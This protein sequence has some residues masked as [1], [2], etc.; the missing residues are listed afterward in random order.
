MPAPRGVLAAGAKSPQQ[1]E[2]EDQD[3][4]AVLEKLETLCNL[5]RDIVL[6]RE[7]DGENATCTKGNGQARSVPSPRYYPTSARVRPLCSRARDPT[8]EGIWRP[9]KMRKRGERTHG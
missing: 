3:A 9:F 2:R 6:A 5:G 7:E 1:P 4:P 8:G